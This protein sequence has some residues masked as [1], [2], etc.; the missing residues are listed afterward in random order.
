MDYIRRNKD[1][2]TYKKKLRRQAMLPLRIWSVCSKLP[3]QIV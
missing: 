3:H 2:T 1:I